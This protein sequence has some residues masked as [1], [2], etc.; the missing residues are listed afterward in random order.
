MTIVDVGGFV[1]VIIFY[2]LIFNMSCG[3]LVMVMEVLG[4]GLLCLCL[5]N[6]GLL[7]LVVV[8]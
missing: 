3:G 2:F 7:G 6:L 1:V 4:L 8:P 5:A